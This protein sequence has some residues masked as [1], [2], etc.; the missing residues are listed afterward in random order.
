MTSFT[1]APRDPHRIHFRLDFIHGHGLPRLRA[2]FPNNIKEAAL[3]RLGT[4]F[5]R[6]EARDPL[7]IQ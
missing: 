4:Q 5:P 3:V 1:R 6:D 7:R 2:Y